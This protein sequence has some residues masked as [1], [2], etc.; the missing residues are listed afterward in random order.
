MPLSYLLFLQ[1]FP[2]NV[3]SLWSYFFVVVS[4]IEH[5]LEVSSFMNEWVFISTWKNQ[6]GGNS[7][8]IN[9]K[10]RVVGLRVP[11]MYFRKYCYGR[12]LVWVLVDTTFTTMGDWTWSVTDPCNSC[13][14]D[15]GEGVRLFQIGRTRYTE[16]HNSTHVLSRRLV[17]ISVFLGFEFLG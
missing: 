11:M 12:D 7:T 6:C 4:H 5:F 10:S 14:R 2:G 16:D 3:R 8:I 1:Q 9:T 15:P 17:R 13:C